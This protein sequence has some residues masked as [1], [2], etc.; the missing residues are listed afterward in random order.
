MLQILIQPKSKILFISEIGD[1]ML[2]YF[3]AFILGLTDKVYE[4][5]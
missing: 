5:E 1:I 3:H 2:G 4:T